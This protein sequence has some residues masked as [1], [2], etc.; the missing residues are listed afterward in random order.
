[1]KEPKQCAYCD[2]IEG[3]E[4]PFKNPIKV[5]KETGELVCWS[6]RDDMLNTEFFG[7]GDHRAQEEM[8]RMVSL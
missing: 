4:S 7:N 5:W 2:Y 6:C 8:E 3:Q 1:M